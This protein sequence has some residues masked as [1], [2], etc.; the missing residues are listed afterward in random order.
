MHHVGIELDHCG[1]GLHVTRQ[2]GIPA[3]LEAPWSISQPGGLERAG[4][5][6]GMALRR[7][8]LLVAGADDRNTVDQIPML[9][10]GDGERVRISI[11][12]L[13]LPFHETARYRAGGG[14]R[15]AARQAGELS[16]I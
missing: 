15:A 4:I 11:L 9:W 14:T 2:Y 7:A 8:S 10:R 1:Q 16:L 13:R 12:R 3:K 6:K 5:C